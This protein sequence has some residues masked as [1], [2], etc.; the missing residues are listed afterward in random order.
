MWKYLGGALFALI[1]WYVA[2]NRS[3]IEAI[4][5][6]SVV[7][8]FVMITL[9]NRLDYFSKILNRMHRPPDDD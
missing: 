1:V 3:E 6:L 4:V 7:V 8:A 9:E 5:L 2:V